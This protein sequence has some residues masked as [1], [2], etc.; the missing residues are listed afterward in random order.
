M[1]KTTIENAILHKS[2]F[3][4]GNQIYR[5]SNFMYVYIL[6]DGS[7]KFAYVNRED[8]NAV[9]GIGVAGTISMFGT[10]EFTDDVTSFNDKT[11]SKMKKGSDRRINADRERFNFLK[12]VPPN[13]SNEEYEEFVID[14]IITKY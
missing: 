12:T 2:T 5:L 7:Q 14:S 8:A 11:I 1:S 3:S 6:R 13:L 9:S 10:F 4:V